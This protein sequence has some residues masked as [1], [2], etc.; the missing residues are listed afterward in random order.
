MTLFAGPEV[1]DN[2]PGHQ[3]SDHRKGN[4]GDEEECRCSH[5]KDHVIAEVGR[6]VEGPVRLKIT[7]LKNGGV[8]SVV[9]VTTLSHGL[10]EN[11]IAAAN[12][13]LFLPKRV[14][15]TPVSVVV[16]REYTFTIY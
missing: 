2:W 16:T 12:R 1:R 7:L 4:R 10:T 6:D 14:N 9:A 5:E 13:I 15:G 11:A 3:T 8:G